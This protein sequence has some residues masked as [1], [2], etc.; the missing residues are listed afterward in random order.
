MKK[1]DFLANLKAMPDCEEKKKLLKAIEDDKESI[2]DDDEDGED[3]PDGSMEKSLD[4]TGLSKA[5]DELEKI[6]GQTPAAAA[7]LGQRLANATDVGLAKSMDA[8]GFVKSL[9]EQTAA[10]AD[11][12]GAGVSEISQQ[13]AINNDAVLA[14]GKLVLGLV[15]SFKDEN[16]RL[17]EKIDRLTAAASGPVQPRTVTSAPMAK[18]FNAGGGAPAATGLSKNQLANA[19]N[20]ELK[21][22]LDAGDQGRAHQLQN[23]VALLM[24]GRK[25]ALAAEIEQSTLRQAKG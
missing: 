5:L 24:A 20:A 21:K 13:Q 10:H 1:K 12:L 19:M 16:A 18:S 2:E 9:V 3:N 11:D 6:Q 17:H 8:T 14:T 15:K 7:P 22:S 4:T 25:D 23:S